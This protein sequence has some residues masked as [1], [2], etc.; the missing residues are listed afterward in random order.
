MAEGGCWDDGEDIM[1]YILWFGG[2]ERDGGGGGR[3]GG[4][5]EPGMSEG[6]MR[7]R[8]RRLYI[9]PGLVGRIHMAT[10]GRGKRRGRK[11]L[12]DEGID[13]AWPAE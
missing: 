1:E 11:K 2:R 12:R 8:R 4:G 6:G 7:R 5:A 13:T 10:D 9:W 3:R